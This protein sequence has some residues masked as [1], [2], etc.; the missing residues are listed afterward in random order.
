MDV[1][2]SIGQQLANSGIAV[3]IEPAK[4]EMLSQ[5]NIFSNTRRLGMLTINGHQINQITLTGLLTSRTQSGPAGSRQL[6]SVT[7]IDVDYIIQADVKVK[8]DTLKARLNV[9]RKGLLHPKV[10]EMKWEGDA[11]AE[12]LNGDAAITELLWQSFG[13]LHARDINIKVDEGS[14]TIHVRDDRNAYKGQMPQFQLYEKIA[15]HICAVAGINKAT[16]LGQQVETPAPK[17]NAVEKTATADP[18]N[19]ATW[20]QTDSKYCF[21]CGENMPQDA[22]F[23]PKCG[24]RQ[25]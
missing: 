23:C 6:R 13:Q 2:E 4:E 22:L 15:G 20:D 24:T 12:K 25:D 18:V 19:T 14:I 7:G 17:S 11:L 3:S 9:K 8:E 16:Q 21:K 10:T 5:L 1:L